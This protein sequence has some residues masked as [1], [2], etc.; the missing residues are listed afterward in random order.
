MNFWKLPVFRPLFL[1]VFLG[2]REMDIYGREGERHMQEEG[3]LSKGRQQEQGSVE[4]TWSAD[5]P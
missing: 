1:V 5:G 2:R 4:R 3:D